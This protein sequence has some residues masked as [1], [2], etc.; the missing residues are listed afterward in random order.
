MTTMQLPQ[1]AQLTDG[2]LRGARCVWCEAP[3]ATT[4]AVDLGIRPHPQYPG[5]RW[6]P[7]ACPSC[8]RAR[9]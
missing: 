2:Q 5:A 9:S 1:P 8:H 7:R 4:A 6:F 3:L